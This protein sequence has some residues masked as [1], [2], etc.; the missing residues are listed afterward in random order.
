MSNLELQRVPKPIDMSFRIKDLN[1]KIKGTRL[2]GLINN[3]YQELDHHGITQFKPL[4]YLSTEWGCLDKVPVI[5]IPFYLADEELMALETTMTEVPAEKEQEIIKILRHEAGHAFNY[6]HELYKKK[7]WRKI[8]GDF[9]SEY[10]D[11]GYKC[12]PFHPAFVCHLP[13]WLAQKHP[14]EDF[15]ET[16]AVWLS[17][18]HWEEHYK[19][20]PAL[21]KLKYVDQIAR[22]LGAEKPKNTKTIFHEPA[23]SLDMTL[24]EYYQV[25]NNLPKVALP[26]FIEAGLRSL[27]PPV[28]PDE[29]TI[30]FKE[31]L[32]KN[33]QKIVNVVYE[34]TGVNEGL[35]W[36]LILELKSSIGQDFLVQDNEA[37]LLRIVSLVTNLAVNYDYSE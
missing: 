32:E 8:F 28:S 25:R 10:K 26:G 37:T 15:A 24:K 21:E 6:A 30:P 12:I 9:E 2:E 1:L 4:C 17:D 19:N 22:S 35:T 7:G 11:F 23:N 27:F 14:D 29:L 13:G 20:A 18:E 33:L 5:S 36:S 16:F 3:L 31:V 34:T